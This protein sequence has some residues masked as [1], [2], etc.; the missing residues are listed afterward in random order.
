MARA[1]KN[2]LKDIVFAIIAIALV[3]SVFSAVK[4]F[5]SK[6]T[7]NISSFS[8]SLGKINADGTI[9]ESETSI[10]SDL[11]P[12]EGLK[13]KYNAERNAEYYVFFYDSD[14]KYVGNSGK[15]SSDFEAE[16]VNGAAYAR[17]FIIP[18]LKEGEEKIRS[19]E[20][21]AYA[22]ALSISTKKE[23][24]EEKK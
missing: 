21:F 6:E 9:S 3:F 4:T 13:V 18:E 12:C 2:N 7:K 15:L 22:N 11:I 8:F 20:V 1:R 14:K 19:W 10:Y 5:F 23:V 16:E 17:I 24:E